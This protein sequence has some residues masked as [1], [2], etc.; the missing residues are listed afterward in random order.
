MDNETRELARL[1]R[2]TSK[3]AG[4]CPDSAA[5]AHVAGGTAWPWQQRRVTTHIAECRHCADEVRTLLAARDGLRD[6]LDLAPHAIPGNNW[7]R[8]PAAA[9]VAAVAVVA[10]VASIAVTQAPEPHT[11]TAAAVASAGADTIFASSFGNDAGQA[12]AGTESRRPDV[13]FRSDFDG[14]RNG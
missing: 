5:L 3:A 13:L 14:S 9:G 2:R 7:L 11:P 1:Y 8:G 12:A 6:A 4:S 10:I